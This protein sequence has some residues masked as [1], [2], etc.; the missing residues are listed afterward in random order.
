MVKIEQ[1]KNILRYKLYNDTNGA[2]IYFTLDLDKYEL[3]ISGET[4]ASY[5]WVESTKETF[6]DLML[7]SDYNYIL[8][9]LGYSRPKEFNLKKSIEETI[10]NIKDNLGEEIILN[11]EGDDLEDFYKEIRT[12]VECYT[13]EEFI[14]I[15]NEIINSYEGLDGLDVHECIEYIEEHTYWL[16]KSVEYFCEYIKPLLKEFNNEN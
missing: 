16:R 15:V 5:K 1:L 11:L 8:M 2:I 4:T 13:S 14:N 9:K 12:G 7:R 10:K 6:I 3:I